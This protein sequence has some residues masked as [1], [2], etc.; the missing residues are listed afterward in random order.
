MYES[1]EEKSKRLFREQVFHQG[2]FTPPDPEILYQ[3][4]K[5]RL[6]RELMVEEE[7]YLVG[8][9]NPVNVRM[10]ILTDKSPMI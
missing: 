5:A 6:M 3:A 10:N 1:E 2:E 7:V 4:I 8:K 9:Y